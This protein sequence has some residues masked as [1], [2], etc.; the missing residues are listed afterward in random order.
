M[1]KSVRTHE[2]ALQ[3]LLNKKMLIYPKYEI[4]LVTDMGKGNPLPIK[5]I[6]FVK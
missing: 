3:F 6:F 5:I 1:I 2:T 4:I